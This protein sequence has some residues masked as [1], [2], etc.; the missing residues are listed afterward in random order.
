M[1]DRRSLGLLIDRTMFEGVVLAANVSSWR[2]V[3]RPLVYRP[4]KGLLMTISIRLEEK[5]DYKKVEFLTREAF[6]DV[7]RPGCVEHLIVHKIRNTPAFIKELSYVACDGDTVIGNIIYSKAKVVNAEG[8]ES[9][10]LCMGPFAVLPSFQKKGTGAR[11]L[12]HSIK[13][14]KEL[15]YKAVIIFGNPEYYQKFGFVNAGNFN[16]TTSAGENFDAFM[17]LELFDGALDGVSGK[18]Y[19]DPVFD[20]KNDEVD[21][22]EKEFPYKEK[23]VTDTQIFR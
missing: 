13:K 2:V 18:H 22:F 1:Q 12:N 3:R 16:I 17:A 10:V 8:K 14:A 19:E 9:E 21:V 4:D 5:Q 20:V 11:L 23:H 15:G 7:Y 6:W